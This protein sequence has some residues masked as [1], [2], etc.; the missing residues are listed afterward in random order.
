MEVLMRVLAD[1]DLLDDKD[2]EDVSHKLVL[3]LKCLT[4]V[5][6]MLLTSSSDQRQVEIS[7]ILE[8]YFKLLNS[9]HIALLANRRSRN[10]ESSFIALQIQML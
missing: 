2:P 3:T 10:W 6:H 5:V 4:E 8:N 9:D 1:C 7:T